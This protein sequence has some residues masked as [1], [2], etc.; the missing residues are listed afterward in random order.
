M[1]SVHVKLPK[2]AAGGQEP[3]QAVADQFQL[4]VLLTLMATI[5]RPP[6]S[7]FVPEILI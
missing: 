2:L 1:C 4:Q 7:D 5:S 3:L 6:E